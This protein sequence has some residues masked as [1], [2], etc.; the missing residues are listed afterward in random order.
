MHSLLVLIDGLGDEPIP[1]WNGATPFEHAQH[2]TMDRLGAMGIATSFSICEDD[3]IPESLSC[4]LRLL[5]VQK[6][7]IPR[8][9]A[10]LELLANN[11]DISEYEMVLRCNLAAVDESGTLIA[12][13]GQGLSAAEMEAA[14]RRCDGILDDIEFIHLSEYRNLLIMDKENF[15]LSC[16]VQPPHESMGLKLE[17]LLRP[18][19]QNSL[20]VTYFLKEANKRL[21]PFARG[22]L[23]YVLYP[24]GAAAR[25][26]LP[27]F[28]SIHGFRAGAVCK[29][30]IVSGM[31]KALDMEVSVPVGATGEV[32][33]DIKAKAIATLKLLEKN[34]FVITHFNGTDEASHRYDYEGKADLIS[35]IDSQFLQFIFANY[36]EPLKVVVCGD[37]VTSSV[38]GRHTTGPTPVIAGCVNFSRL[39][40]SIRSYRDIL[41]FLMKESE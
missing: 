34:T 36:K 29:A 17:Q 3:I 16:D 33:T 6:K 37:H 18:L 5:G 26:Q 7:N 11:R 15:V 31:A 40:V 1:A 20:P 28:F 14:A 30:E 19:L 25:Q 2:P 9:R 27:S 12:F 23:R 4:I 39:P 21:R 41:G 10:Y 38:T 32:D 8:N 35:T 22:G 13:N 24:W